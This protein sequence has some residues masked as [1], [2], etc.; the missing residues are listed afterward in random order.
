MFTWTKDQPTKVGWYW[1]RNADER[2][3]H[4]GAEEHI[5]YV[6]DYVGRLCIANWEIPDKD[7]EWAGPIPFPNEE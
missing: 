6:R 5:V 2:R 3:K 1:Q 4:W 7:T